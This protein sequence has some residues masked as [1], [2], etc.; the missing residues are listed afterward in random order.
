MATRRRMPEAVR[1]LRA[2]WPTLCPSVRELTEEL[3]HDFRFGQRV[4]KTENG[5]VMGGTLKGGSSSIWYPATQDQYHA[6]RRWR[7]REGIVDARD[8]EALEGLLALLAQHEIALSTRRGRRS[9]LRAVAGDEAPYGGYGPLYGDIA[10]VLAELPAPHLDRAELERI[11]LGGWGPDAAKAS[12]YVDGAVMMYDFACRG[13]RRTFL[14]LFLHELGH[15]HEVAMDEATRDALYEQYEVLLEEDA[16]VGVEF[17]L[18]AET[19]RLYQRF[20]FNEFLAETYLLYTACG[21]RLRE[22][23]AG[24]GPAARAAW[25]RVYALYRDGFAGIEYE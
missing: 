5:Y 23:I 16:F 17:L 6:Y 25:E 22:A 7:Q 21:G 24:C 15:A 14:G 1:A 11:Q 13:A 20:V 10:R 12:A 18:D 3:E 2:P 8:D 19:R 4:T 9:A